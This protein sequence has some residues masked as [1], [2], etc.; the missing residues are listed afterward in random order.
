MLGNSPQIIR[1]LQQS[2]IPLITMLA[3]IFI[4]I[5]P[6]RS[7]VLLVLMPLLT[8]IVLYFWTIHRPRSLPY[9]TIFLLGL[10]KD[11]LEN[12]V[13]G[14]NAL[15][16][17]IFNFMAKSQRKYIINRAFIVIWAGFVFFLTVILLL[18]ILL[19]DLNTNIELY[20][21]KIIVIQWCLTVFT[22]VPIHFLL[23]KLNHLNSS[24]K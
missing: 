20:S 22:Y 23:S 17:L 9:T 3:S 24:N 4:P 6:Y 8:F 2:I 19:V 18:S 5:L 12:S 10:L 1:S 7:N 15:C 13:F 11:I 16:L 21:T 14:L